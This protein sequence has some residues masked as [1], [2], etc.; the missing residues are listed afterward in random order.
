M[1][2]RQFSKWARICKSRPALK[3]QLGYGKVRGCYFGT[4]GHVDHKSIVS[5]N[6]ETFECDVDH[7]D[8][9]RDV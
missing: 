5:E 3:F 4:L 6:G 8:A 9:E 1:S 2:R 7:F